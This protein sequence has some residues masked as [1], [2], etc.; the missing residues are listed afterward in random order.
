MKGILEM[1]ESDTG[2]FICMLTPYVS[3]V[4]TYDTLIYITA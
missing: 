1:R 4:A 3:E 2:I